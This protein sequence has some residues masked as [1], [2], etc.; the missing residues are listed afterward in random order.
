MIKIIKGTYGHREGSRIIPKTPDDEPFKLAPEK[1]ARLVKEGVAAYFQPS[2]ATPAAQTTP[3]KSDDGQAEYNANMK[4]DELKQ[5]AINLGAD[6]AAV[7]KATSK[8]K[9][10]ELIEAAKAA[11]GQSVDDSQEDDDDGEDEDEAGTAP[12]NLTP[13]DPEV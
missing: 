3:A 13:A 9:V 5:I 4:L 6:E 11:A 1:E 7:K 8:A 12:P 2:G 10:I